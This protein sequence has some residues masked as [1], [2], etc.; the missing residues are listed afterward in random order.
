M[1]LD[2]PKIIDDLTE[3]MCGLLQRG[4]YEQ[5]SNLLAGDMPKPC[6]N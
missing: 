4:V 3:I 6:M 2:S 5:F 1:N